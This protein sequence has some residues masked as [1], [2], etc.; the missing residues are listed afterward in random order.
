MS[1]STSELFWSKQ[2]PFLCCC[3]CVPSEFFEIHIVSRVEFEDCSVLFHVR[4]VFFLWNGEVRYSFECLGRESEFIWE[5]S[6]GCVEGG[7][8]VI[9]SSCSVVGHVEFG[10]L[11]SFGF[12]SFP[13]SLVFFNRD[14]SA[15]GFSVCWDFWPFQGLDKAC[16]I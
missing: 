11:A 3:C 12:L 9:V 16:C 1:F 2:F 4:Y 10:I 14:C 6:E 13:G 15:L 7:Y 5:A 8:L